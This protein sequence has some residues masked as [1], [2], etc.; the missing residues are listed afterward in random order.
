MFE[1]RPDEALCRTVR[2]GSPADVERAIDE[3]MAV[4][5][6]TTLSMAMI[7]AIEEARPEVLQLL[8]R[9]GHPDED[10]AQAAARSEN[11]DIVGLILDSGWDVNKPLR[12]GQI[13]SILR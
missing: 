9:H 6:P 12:G 1:P 7:A 10:V 5:P 11:T 4:D 2:S 8:L 3:Y 13:P